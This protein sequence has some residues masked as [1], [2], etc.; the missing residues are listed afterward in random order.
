[1][2]LWTVRRRSLFLL[3]CPPCTRPLHQSGI[4]SMGSRAAFRTFQG[5]L[6]LWPAILDLESPKTRMEGGGDMIKTHMGGGVACH[7]VCPCLLFRGTYITFNFSDFFFKEL[8]RFLS[9]MYRLLSLYHIPDTFYK[10]CDFLRAGL[11]RSKIT[12]VV[13][14]H[15]LW[16]STIH[17]GPCS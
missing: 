16:H 9:F 4:R 17:P 5:P 8:L 6:V 10:V 15:S 14:G 2:G 12:F 7:R 3:I 1:M 11:W 13:K